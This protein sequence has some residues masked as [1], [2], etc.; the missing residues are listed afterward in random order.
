LGGIAV[1]SDARTLGFAIVSYGLA[2]L[3]KFGVVYLVGLLGFWTH[4]GWGLVNGR[5]ALTRLFSGALVPLPFMP[6]WLESLAQALPF[7]AM[8]Y[9]PSTIYL[10]RQ[11]DPW[12]ALGRLAFARAVQQVTIHGG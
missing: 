10:G 12:A 5:I 8:V 9:L 2:V 4:N 1:P 6:G 7:Q 11:P 3:I